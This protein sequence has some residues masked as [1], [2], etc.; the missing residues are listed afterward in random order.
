MSDANV[1]EKDVWERLQQIIDPELDCNIVA[2]GLIYRVAV[3]G[4]R[5]AV[6]MTLTTP[7]CPMNE[8]LPAAV[9]SSLEEI[10]GVTEASV[11]LTWDPP[12]HFS[13]ISSAARLQLGV[14]A[15]E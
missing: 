9:K 2:L 12:W 1:S 7:G 5:V 13:K 3:E 15:E 11:E 6:T 10:E 8:I 14:P 4:S